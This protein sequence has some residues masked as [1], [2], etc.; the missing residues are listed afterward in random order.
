AFDYLRSNEDELKVDVISLVP[1]L[2]VR[3]YRL[4]RGGNGPNYGMPLSVDRNHLLFNAMRMK[5]SGGFEPYLKS[6]CDQFWQAFGA[7]GSPNFDANGK[8]AP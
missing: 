7:K 6:I 1:M 5:L 8:W 4:H 3:G 2:N